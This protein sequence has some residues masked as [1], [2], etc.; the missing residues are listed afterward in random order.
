MRDTNNVYYIPLQF[1]GIKGYVV[2]E[3]PQ[4]KL[5]KLW[6]RFHGY[7]ENHIVD[8]GCLVKLNEHSINDS[9][10]FHDD[11][12]ISQEIK[13]V[14]GDQAETFKVTCPSLSFW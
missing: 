10:R 3:N 11:H 14:L 5:Q 1:R 12:Q 7:V 4:A 13:D 9:I 8:P 2:K 6:V